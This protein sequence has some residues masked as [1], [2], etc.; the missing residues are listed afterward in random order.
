MSVSEDLDLFISTLPTIPAE[1]RYWLI[2]TQSGSLYETFRT[3]GFVGLEH[4]E[5][6]LFL[7]NTIRNTTSNDDSKTLAAIRNRVRSVHEQIASEEE[8]VD[9]R[10]SGLISSQI[11]RFVYE[12][13]KNDTVII[14][15]YGSEIISFGEFI[16]SHIGEFTPE[17]NRR[18]GVDMILK[19]RVRWVKDILRRD[20]DP[21]LY[22]M[23][24]AH[25]AIF[26]AGGYAE[27]IERSLH[28]F[29]VLDEEAHI[30]INVE[31]ENEIPATDLFGLGSEILRLVDAFAAE[32]QLDIS[33]NQ[34]QV[35]INV[36]SPGKIDLKSKIK[37]V[38]LIT[39]L[40]L[41]AF[42]GGYESKEWGSL[43]SPGLPGLI[44]AIDEF[45]T[46]EQERGMKQQIFD[47]YKDSLKIKNPD[48]LVKLLKQVSDN[49][50][51]PK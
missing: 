47:K 43:A 22:K 31:T 6:P 18:F 34:L 5:V 48:D 23:F 25:Q 2:R 33:S 39:G 11:F 3:N 1:K 16:E 45:K 49:K 44:K 32:N 19:K 20:L 14:P 40:I 46:H 4:N 9:L 13:K 27:I 42:G 29:F 50:D 38:T 36:N 7:L 41:A 21:Y 12:T 15:S 10:K 24:T 35:S 51:L 28:D 8:G 30:I 37:K 26:D 17:E